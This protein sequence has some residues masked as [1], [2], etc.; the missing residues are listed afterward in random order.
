MGWG[1][2]IFLSWNDSNLCAYLPLQKKL[3]IGICLAILLLIIII[4]LV[5]TFSS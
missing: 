5:T 4:A 3:W 1:G 2:L